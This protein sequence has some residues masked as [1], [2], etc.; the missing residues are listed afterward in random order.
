MNK[1]PT[2][3]YDV[4]FFRKQ[5]FYDGYVKGKKK[6]RHSEGSWQFYHYEE[7]YRVGQEKRNKEEQKY[8]T[9]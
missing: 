4:N 7:G 8:K 9:K 1:M 5:G 6:P 3:T 2:G